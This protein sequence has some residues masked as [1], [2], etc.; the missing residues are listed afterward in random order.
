MGSAPCLLLAQIW[1]LLNDI[2]NNFEK[3]KQIE[4]CRLLYTRVNP[5]C[6]TELLS[7]KISDWIKSQN[8]HFLSQWWQSFQI[9]NITYGITKLWMRLYFL[10][11]SLIGSITDRIFLLTNWQVALK[12][13]KLISQLL[14]VSFINIVLSA[15]LI[16]LLK[17]HLRQ[18]KF[19]LDYKLHVTRNIW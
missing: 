12:R 6:T 16:I 2:W 14:L 3:F 9:P 18:V 19:R 1:T 5:V 15:S 13:L 10:T 4:T 7:N 11:P 8:L 17:V